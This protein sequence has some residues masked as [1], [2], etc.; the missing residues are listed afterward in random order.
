MPIGHHTDLRQ[1]PMLRRFY[2]PLLGHAAKLKLGPMELLD[3]GR[4]QFGE[5][6]ALN[7]C[8]QRTAVLSGPKANEAF[9]RAGD[10]QFSTRE[11]YQLL[12]PIFGKGIVYDSPPAIMDE[13]LGFLFPA[14]KEQRL[15]TYVGWF[16]EELE[17]YFAA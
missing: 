5:I 13:Q 16:Q 17:R 10:D 11:A 2:L 4:R 8:G 1:P 6:F 14:L 7:L 9:F 3:E 15:R 12:V